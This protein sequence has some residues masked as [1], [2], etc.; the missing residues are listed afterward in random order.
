MI[1]HDFMAGN[2]QSQD[3]VSGSLTLDNVF[4]ITAPYCCSH[5]CHATTQHTLLFLRAKVRDVLY[6][7]HVPWPG[8]GWS[9]AKNKKD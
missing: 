8:S 2:W 7:E 6:I 3:S 5:L 9:A 1:F 4:F